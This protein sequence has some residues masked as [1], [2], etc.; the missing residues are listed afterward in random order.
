MN[1]PIL[2]ALLL[3]SKFVYQTNPRNN[4]IFEKMDNYEDESSSA[5]EYVRF[6]NELINSYLIGC[7]NGCDQV[8]KN[9]ISGLGNLLPL[10][11]GSEGACKDQA[12]NCAK[13]KNH[14]SHRTVLKACSKTCGHCG[15]Q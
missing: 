3:L 11:H 13:F 12:M 4:S 8:I 7:V 14:C 6:S 5:E 9:E 1:G 2:L 10:D 15:T